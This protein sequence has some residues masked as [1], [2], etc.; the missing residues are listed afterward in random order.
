M[1]I[2]TCFAL[3][4]VHG[5]PYHQGCQE[6]LHGRSYRFSKTLL[7]PLYV[8]YMCTICVLY[9]YYVCTMCVHYLCTMCVHYVC[10]IGTM[11]ANYMKCVLPDSVLGIYIYN[12]YMYLLLSACVVLFHKL[13]T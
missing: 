4:T 9:V 1:Q 2:Y 12:T 6:D 3:Y 5:E 13:L 7:C 10:A 11:L 8:Y